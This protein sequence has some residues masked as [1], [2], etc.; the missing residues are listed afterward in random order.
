[1]NGQSLRIHSFLPHSRANGPGVRAVVWTQGCS[2]GCPGCYNPGTHPQTDGVAIVVD[3]LCGRLTALADTLEGL[4]ISG[5][6]PLQQRPA[7][8]ALLRRVRAETALSVLLFTGYSWDEVQRFPETAALLANIDVLLAG[9]YDAAQHLGRDL[10]GSA[11]KT[12][13]FLTTRYTLADL[14]AVPAAEVVIAA[15]GQIVVSGI[16]PVRW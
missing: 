8:L 6:E 9:R 12:M 11:N 10:R 15:D 3:D 7:L 4:T 1:M 13:H 5:G 16:D 2:L 14:A